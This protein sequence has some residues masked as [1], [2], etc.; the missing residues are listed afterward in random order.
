MKEN[1]DP[2]NLIQ[3]YYDKESKL[4]DIL[5][6]HSQTV[7]KKAVE[8]ATNIPH[9]NP[10]INFIKEAAMLHDIGIFLTNLQKI[11][12]FGENPYISHGHLGR[13]ILESEGYPLHALVCERHVGV[14]ISIQDIESQKL[15]IPKRSMLPLSI[16]EKIIC[17]A[18]K[19]FTKKETELSKEQDIDKVK[20]GLEKFG[21]DKSQ[22]FDELLAELNI[23]Q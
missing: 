7:T 2:I 6:Q 22:R 8:I 3:K 15:P 14:G 21:P 11:Q 23:I 18:D 10:N 17:I 13:K 19:F 20:K 5:I 16:E 12:C 1:L 9:L 4:Y